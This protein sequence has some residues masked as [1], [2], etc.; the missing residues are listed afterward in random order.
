VV[1]KALLAG[2]VAAIRDAVARIRSVLPATAGAFASDRTTREVVTLNL[3]VALQD[4]I[5]LAAH[6][7]AD[8]GRVVPASY[9]EV[10]AA[11][12]AA[13]VID[14]RLAARLRAAAGLRNLVAHQYGVL[15]ADRLF[16]VARDDLED[17]LTFCQQ[18]SARASEGPL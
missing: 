9:A 15:D 7:L 4:A 5:A 3:F 1:D 13:G 11:L 17:L 16:V 14:D 18:L 6:W 8:E 2:R 12:G 10:F